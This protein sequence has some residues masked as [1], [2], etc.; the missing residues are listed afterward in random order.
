MDG[1]V[2]WF[3]WEKE[4]EMDYFLMPTF[5]IL[6][7]SSTISPPH[8]FPFLYW[9]F[10]LLIMKKKK[11]RNY[12]VLLT[13]IDDLIN[14]Q[15]FL[16]TQYSKLMYTCELWEIKKKNLLLF[17]KRQSMK[18]TLNTLIVLFISMR[19]IHKAFPLVIIIIDKQSTHL[20]FIHFI[21]FTEFRI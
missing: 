8:H 16:T 18:Y 19:L 21:R 3:E 14:H 12:Y 17:G 15:K 10:S 5:F 6:F 9:A 1:W 7:L 11:L 13:I 20:Q 2:S 4:K